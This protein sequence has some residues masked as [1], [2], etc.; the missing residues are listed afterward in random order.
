MAKPL[1]YILEEFDSPI[2]GKPCVAIMTMKSNNKKTG[3]M[4]QVYILRRDKHPKEVID[5]HDDQSICGDCIHRADP[6]TGRARTC[7]VNV[8]MQGVSQVWNTYKQG[9]YAKEFT[10]QEGR[11]VLKGRHIRWGAYGDPAMINPQIFNA[12]NQLAAGHTGYTHQWKKNFAQVYKNNF[13][14]SVDSYYDQK[15]AEAHGWKTYHVAPLGI[16]GQGVKCPNTV[17]GSM[18]KCLTCGLCDG[19]KTNVWIEIHGPAKGQWGRYNKEATRE[20]SHA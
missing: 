18:S 4:C 6:E 8:T 9:G 19:D 15:L 12:V 10:W 14:A 3:N 1:G 13:M 11:K 17:E 2:D 16:T 5:Q 20:V 7:Y